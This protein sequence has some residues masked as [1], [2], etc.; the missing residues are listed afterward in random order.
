MGLRAP[1]RRFQ[2][3]SYDVDDLT[4]V[5]FEQAGRKHQKR[6]RDAH[7]VHIDAKIDLHG[8]TV[9]QAY[10]TSRAFIHKMASRHARWV[11]IVTGKSGVLFDEVPK[12]LELM[13]E[14]VKSFHHARESQGGKGA[15]CV[16]LHNV[17]QNN[18]TVRKHPSPHKI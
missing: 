2:P 16:A 17:S 12:W 3:K 9:D 13:T 11:L 10:N 5:E 4:Y 1:A 15:L 7:K 8:L 6:R 18:H 14:S